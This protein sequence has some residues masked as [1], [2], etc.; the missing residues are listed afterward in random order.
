MGMTDSYRHHSG[1]PEYSTKYT[2]IEKEVSRV[3][4]EN[5]RK[6]KW[7]MKNGPK[8]KV[9]AFV[10]DVGSLGGGETPFL[11]SEM[12]ICPACRIYYWVYYF[13]AFITASFLS[14]ARTYAHNAINPQTMCTDINQ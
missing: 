12:F 2:E 5:R 14:L 3:L 7:R 9:Q 11:F 1:D 10:C 8:I 4:R 13:F 6:R